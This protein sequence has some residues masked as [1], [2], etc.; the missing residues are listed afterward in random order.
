MRL[1]RTRVNGSEEAYV[2]PLAGPDGMPGVAFQW[3]E[4]EGPLDG[5]AIAGGYQLMFGD[6]PIRRSKEGESG[7]VP[8]QIVAPPGSAGANT[9]GR[10]RFGPRMQDVAV[11]VVTDHPREDAERLLHA[12][13]GRAYRR[14]IEE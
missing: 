4:V 3:I 5:P 14:P 8:V 1:F 2:N 9:G 11:E 6:L 7:G 10:G 12:F 13:I